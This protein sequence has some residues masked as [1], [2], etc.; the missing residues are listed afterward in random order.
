MKSPNYSFDPDNGCDLEIVCTR[1]ESGD[2]NGPEFFARR[3]DYTFSRRVYARTLRSNRVAVQFERE[4]QLTGMDR[5]CQDKEKEML[6][7]FILSILFY[8]PTHEPNLYQ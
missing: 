5:D 8:S 4:K 6:L 2:G 1:D 3:R 7:L